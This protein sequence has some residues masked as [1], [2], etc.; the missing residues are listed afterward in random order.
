MHTYFEKKM[1]KWDG[2]FLAAYNVK[3]RPTNEHTNPIVYLLTF[4]LIRLSSFADV[5]M[6]WLWCYFC[7]LSWVRLI[8]AGYQCDIPDYLMSDH[9]VA[10][11]LPMKRSV[12]SRWWDLKTDYF[13]D[14]KIYHIIIYISNIKLWKPLNVMKY[15]IICIHVMIHLCPMG[16]CL[17]DNRGV[18]P[19]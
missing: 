17:L 8:C 1:L 18:F 3:Y 13:T 10:L 9:A 14:H 15:R 12:T 7:Y 5:R 16:R 4:H 2:D 6:L 19:P 11:D